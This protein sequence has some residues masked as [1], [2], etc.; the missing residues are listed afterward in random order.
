M[1]IFK[2]KE[3]YENYGQSGSSA[4]GYLPKGTNVK[5]NPQT[6]QP[7]SYSDVY[8]EDKYPIKCKFKDR[9]PDPGIC[10]VLEINFEERKIW[11]SN[12]AISSTANFDDIEFIPDIF[13]F[14][15]YNL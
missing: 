4:T 10:Y 13:V 15:K 1:K 2:F 6:L 9:I 12:E 14:G 11:W 3:K 8:P 5:I 7:L